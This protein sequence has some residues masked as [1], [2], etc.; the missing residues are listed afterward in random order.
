M[1]GYMGDNEARDGAA[2]FSPRGT[3]LGSTPSNRETVS[4]PQ[5]PKDLPLGPPEFW[6]AAVDLDELAD[7]PDVATTPALKNLGPL[8]LSRGGFP[9]MGFLATIY[10]QIAACAEAMESK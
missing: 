8:P 4:S 9:L 1:S 3:P 5:P 10:E 6:S 2:D 7:P